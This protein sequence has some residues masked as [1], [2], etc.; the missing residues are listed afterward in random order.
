[1]Q[2]DEETMQSLLF[3]FPTLDRADIEAV[4][5]RSTG[6]SVARAMLEELADRKPARGPGIDSPAVKVVGG[7]WTWE[8]G[9]NPHFRDIVAQFWMYDTRPGGQREVCVSL[10]G[11]NVHAIRRAAT[12]IIGHDPE[13]V[14]EGVSRAG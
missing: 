3:D 10:Y 8:H 7:S 6:E 12:A 5:D 4:T 11:S 9:W 1:M 2:L 13:Q 14:I